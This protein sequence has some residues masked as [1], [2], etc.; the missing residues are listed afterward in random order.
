MQYFRKWCII[1]IVKG[2]KNKP[3]E[4]TEKEKT[5]QRITKEALINWASSQHADDSDSVNELI[6]SLEMYPDIEVFDVDD[7][8]GNGM[9]FT[10]EKDGAI[11]YSGDN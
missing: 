5:M 3:P 2:T 8:N 10:V 11:L 4:G 1:Y 6:D 9:N 7:G